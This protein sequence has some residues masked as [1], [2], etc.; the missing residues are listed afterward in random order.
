MH[1]AFRRIDRDLVE[2]RGAKPRLLGVHIAE[3]PSLQQRVVR[4]VDAGHDV[5]R[6]EGHLLG[7]GKEVVGVPVQHHA[8]DDADG[9]VLLGD[10]LGRVQDVI[11]LLG[12][13]FRVKGLDAQFPFRE[14]ARI[15]GPPTGPD[16]DSPGS[17][18]R[19]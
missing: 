1:R 7:F 17:R 19:S 16:D 3:Q 11:G 14:V 4:K 2:V 18:R 6:Q 12:G 15:D 10:Q 9:D 5:R 8:A 13:P